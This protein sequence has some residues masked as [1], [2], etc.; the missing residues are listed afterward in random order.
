MSFESRSERSRRSLSSSTKSSKSG[1]LCEAGCS[2]GAR[3]GEVVRWGGRPGAVTRASRGPAADLYVELPPSRSHFSG[4]GKSY[5]FSC[6][7][8]FQ[9]TYPYVVYI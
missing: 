3:G 1:T 4:F 9:F 8:P 5:H 6:V 7:S 2:L